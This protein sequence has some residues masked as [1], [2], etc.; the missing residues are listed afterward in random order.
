LTEKGAGEDGCQE[1]KEDPGKKGESE[2]QPFVEH[3]SGGRVEDGLQ[4][5]NY[6]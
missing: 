3:D 6:V 1:Q 4:P 5:R 2:I